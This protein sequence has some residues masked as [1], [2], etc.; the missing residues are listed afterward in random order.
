MLNRIYVY[1]WDQLSEGAGAVAAALQTQKLLRKKSRYG[2]QRGD[3]IVNWGA[4][5]IGEWLRQRVSP[6]DGVVVLN[7]DVQG[8]L[9]KLVFFDRTDGNPFVPEYCVSLAVAKSLAFPVL[10]RTK[11]KGMDGEG[12]VIASNE[13]ELVDAPLYVSMKPKSAEYRVHVGRGV[14]G[15]ASIM[16]I[17]RKFLPNGFDGDKRLRVGDDCYFVW[18]VKGKE[19]IDEAPAAVKEASLAVFDLFPELTFGGLDVIYD[20]LSGKAW[21]LEINSAPEQTDRSAQMYADFF[22]QYRQPPQK[23]EVAAVA[24]VEQDG[25]QPWEAAYDVY[26]EGSGYLVPPAREAF[27]AGWKARKEAEFGRIYNG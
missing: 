6:K 5:D 12:I 13:K 19:V 24:V 15:K 26:V 9:N 1:P 8:A 7:P 14:D 3:V 22:Q 16:G 25:K 23:V 4:S 18:T 27:E 10:C 17:Q 20:G 11:I 2:P 21:V